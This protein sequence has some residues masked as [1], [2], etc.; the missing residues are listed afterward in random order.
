MQVHPSTLF[1]SSFLLRCEYELESGLGSS[2]LSERWLVSECAASWQSGRCPPLPRTSSSLARYWEWWTHRS[3][4][5]QHCWRTGGNTFRAHRS[6]TSSGCY[7][8]WCHSEYLHTCGGVIF[9]YYLYHLHV[10]HHQN[11]FS[12]SKYKSICQIVISIYHGKNYP[13]QPGPVWKS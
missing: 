9:W 4:L 5:H 8:L 10:S 11:S 1:L 6:C 7:F 12:I 2:P 13:N 3:F